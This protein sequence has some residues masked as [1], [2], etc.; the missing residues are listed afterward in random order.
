MKIVWSC[1][2][3]LIHTMPVRYAKNDLKGAIELMIQ[4]ILAHPDRPENLIIEEKLP[5][6]CYRR[7]RPVGEGVTP[8]MTMLIDGIPVMLVNVRKH[9]DKAVMSVKNL[10]APRLAQ[11]LCKAKFKIA[12]WTMVV[13]YGESVNQQVLSPEQVEY[14]SLFDF[15]DEEGNPTEDI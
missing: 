1:C 12:P 10:D 5:I 9:T 3:K 6:H 2:C 7:G 14:D 13:Y 8:T 4:E 15:L 11:E